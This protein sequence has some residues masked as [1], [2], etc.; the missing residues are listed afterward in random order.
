VGRSTEGCPYIAQWL[1][2]YRTR[3]GE[4]CERALRRYVPEAG[5]LTSARD[6]IP[7]VAERV[8]RAVSVWARTGEV[9][10]VP[11]EFAHLVAEHQRAGNQSGAR[12]FA[13]ARDGGVRGAGEPQQIQSQL[14]AG[15]ALDSNVR[16]RMESAFGHDFS[17][18]RIHSDS[19]A[20]ALSSRLN[21]RAFTVGSDIA[22]G[23]QEYQPGTLVGDAL[24]AHELAHVMQQ[25]AAGVSDSTL[26]KGGA[27]YGALEE[28]ADNS[29]V[30]AIL[31]MWGGIKG[32]AA[33]I[34]QRA[35][36]SLKSGLR[37]QRCD[38]TPR[39]RKRTVAGP[40]TGDCD[41]YSWGSQWY[42]E[43]AGSSNGWIVQKVQD[44]F[45]V[46]D[47]AGTA[48]SN[49]DIMARNGGL[50]PS[51]FPYWEAW[52][53]RSGTVYVGGG[54]QPHRA[55]TYNLNGISGD[56]RGRERIIGDAEFYHN[57]TLPSSF[58]VRANHPAASLPVATSA[59]TLTGGTGALAHNLTANW[60]CCPTSPSRATRIALT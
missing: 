19:Q 10:G 11:D 5:S 4:Q 43:N 9:V 33:K 6:Y 16:S 38:N 40:T 21:A 15:A 44:I 41:T 60:N 55:D 1:G 20:A 32:A 31:S 45:E 48:L 30:G 58:S 29:A 46:T 35:M 22:F 27:A 8:R 47:C 14:G 56:S 42:L 49:A 26:Q 59:P 36:P 57:L 12:I 50:D 34:S 24:L 23:G 17:R 28:D 53:V 3:S 13:K 7:M 54:T 2:Y 51:L 39:L 18:V 52:Q 37:L 25:E